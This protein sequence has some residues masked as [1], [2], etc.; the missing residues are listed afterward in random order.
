[1]LLVEGLLIR[2]IQVGEAWSTELLNRGD[3]LRPWLED[4]ASFVEARWHVAEPAQIAILE[5]RLTRQLAE[6][7]VLIEELVERGLRRSRSMAVHAAIAAT[8]RIEDRLLL[9]FWHLAERWGQ[10][11]AD[12]VRLD[13]P[14]T[15]G[16][17]AHTIGAQRPTVTTAL[18]SLAERDQV[19]RASD[20][21][22]MLRGSAPTPPAIPADRGE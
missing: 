6:W 13:L 11:Q 4:A 22:W 7:P 5:P 3:L 21:A 20:G 2:E 1:M 8:R 16:T 10:T 17:L 19:V 9:L 15:H 18:S 14:L 12:G